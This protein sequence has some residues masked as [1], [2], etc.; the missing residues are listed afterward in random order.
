MAEAA[1][2]R[3]ETQEGTCIETQHWIA[4]A[5]LSWAIVST[6]GTGLIVFAFKID[7]RL[8][9]IETKFATFQ[10]T[11]RME[12]RRDLEVG[13]FPIIGR[14]SPPDVGD[15]VEI[16]QQLGID[17]RE[18]PEFWSGMR[19]LIRS[20]PKDLADLLAWLIAR[21]GEDTIIQ[22]AVVYKRTILGYAEFW[23]VCVEKARN[24]GVPAMVGKF[25]LTE[26][27]FTR[28]ADAGEAMRANP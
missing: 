16:I 3:G 23:G 9:V 13:E 25:G 27:E 5:A 21:Y 4:L 1:H 17:V 18:R 6:I 12:G 24:D 20:D 14:N 8:T 11:M 26:E 28:L 7:R 19:E 2:K 10:Q 15:I 22:R